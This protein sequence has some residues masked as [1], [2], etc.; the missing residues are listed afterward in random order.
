M[1]AT[2]EK[3]AA[4]P[5]K[6]GD[7]KTKEEKINEIIADGGTTVKMEVDY[8]AT[9]DEKLPVAESLAEAGKLNEAIEMLMSLEKQTRTGADTHSSGRVLVLIVKLCAKAGDWNQLN[10]KIMELTK[11]RSQLK[12][13]V[14]KMVAECCTFLDLTP[15]KP[16]LLKLIDTLRT[17]TAGKIYVENE[18]A[19][20]THRLSQIKEADGDMVEAAKIMQELQVETYGSMERKE[21]VELILEQMR[22][23]LATED[24]IRTQ[25]I[26]KK[27][28][29]KFFEDSAHDELRLKFYNYMIRL[30]LHE[31]DY[32]GICKNYRAV[33]ESKTIQEDQEKKMTAMKNVVIFIILSKYD[34]EQSDLIHRINKEKIMQDLPRYKSMLERFITS[35]LINQ[36]AF[37]QQ[38]EKELRD[39]VEGSQPTGTF[40]RDEAG[41]TRWKDLLTRIVEHNIRIMAKYYTRISLKRMA[42]LLALPETQAEDSLSE[43]V[44]SGA[45][46]AKTDRLEGII[47]FSQQQDPLEN[48]NEWSSNTNKLMDLV[49]KTT[50]LINKEEM[51]NK[52]LVSGPQND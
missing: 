52:H 4:S 28:S 13:A 43:M 26:S 27:I 18:R 33:F 15:D 7:D 9:C 11:K 12:Q 17:V 44:V 40:S 50:H 23:C 30:G 41:E 19:R 39:G 25:I 29:T 20:L 10:E 42:E 46:S 6:K 51:V 24:Y 1:T 14:A 32:L 48:L 49:M 16:T 3:P 21:K 37:C 2:Q 22:L 5:K 45:V 38:F 31:Q 34:N 47:D 8:S 35:E 36:S